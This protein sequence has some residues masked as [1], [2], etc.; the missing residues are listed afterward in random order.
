MGLNRLVTQPSLTAEPWVC[1]DVSMADDL[2]ARLGP[3]NFGRISR[4]AGV[5]KFHV[6]RFLKGTRGASFDV[7]G[8][9][10]EAAGVSLDELREWLTPSRSGRK[11]RRTQKDMIEL[12]D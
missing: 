7:A 6:S 12:E 1:F 4:R 9:I 3:G 5:S 8:D 2:G 10:A 11:G